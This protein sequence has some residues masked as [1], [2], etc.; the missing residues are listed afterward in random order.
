MTK[1]QFIVTGN[2]LQPNGTP[3][4]GAK[5]TAFDRDMRSEQRLGKATTSEAGRYKITY[6]AGQFSR[7][8]KKSAD[9][10]VRAEFEH[11]GKK[12]HAESEIHFN[13]G[14]MAQIDLILTPVPEQPR[15]ALSEIELLRDEIESLR[16]QV[17][18]P[19]FTADD[20]HFLS[21]ELARRSGGAFAARLQRHAIL[22]LLGFLRQAARSERE[23]GIPLAAFYGWYRLGLP[24]ELDSLLDT[25]LS[26]LRDALEE[27]ISENIIPD[28]LE[29]VGEVLSRITTLHLK[30]GKISIQRFIGQLIDRKSGRP[31]INHTVHLFDP[32]DRSDPIGLGQDITDARGL[33]FFSV[34]L[35]GAK[36][37]DDNSR[38]RELRLNIKDPDGDE[39]AQVLE[40]VAGDQKKP[41]TIPISVPPKEDISA[42]VEDVASS[43]LARVLHERGLHNMTDILRNGGLGDL[44]DIE[45]AEAERLEAHAR[46]SVLSSD[47]ELNTALID[48]GYTGPLTIA[49]ASRAAF[50]TELAP[51]I[52]DYQAIKL[53]MRAEAQVKTLNNILVGLRRELVFGNLDAGTVANFGLNTELIGP[54][55][56]SCK[57]CEASVSPLAYLA[58]LLE[59]AVTYVKDDGND[60]NHVTWLVNAFK[61]P[62]GDL[63]ATCETVEERVRQVRLCVEV[64]RRLHIENQTAGLLAT[65]EPYRHKAYEA[66]LTQLGTSLHELQLVLGVGDE[67]EIKRLGERLAILPEHLPELL[68]DLEALPSPLTEGSLEEIFGLVDTTRDPLEEADTPLLVTW[69]KEYL[70][71]L[72]RNLDFPEDAYTGHA[73]PFI[74]PD[75]IG[76]DDFRHPQE[77]EPAF[78]LWVNRRTL[79]DTRVSAIRE[80]LTV[81]GF[82]SAL[83]AVFGDPPPDLRQLTE[84]LS[85]GTDVQ[86]TVAVLED[87]NLTPER[88]VKLA[89]LQA[90]FSAEQPFEDEE[91][92]DVANILIQVEKQELYESWISEEQVDGVLLDPRMFWQSLREPQ[93][94]EWPPPPQDQPLIDPQVL[95]LK[96]LLEPNAGQAAIDIFNEREAQLEQDYQTLRNT[97]EGDGFEAMMQLALGHPDPGDQLQHD[98]DQL[99]TDLL[100]DNEAS[101]ASAE[102]AIQTDF[103]L[104][105]E[106]FN[107]LM[108]AR[109]RDATPGA[110]PSSEELNQVYAILTVARKKKHRYPDWLLEETQ[111]AV[112]TYWKI[113]KA[114]L[115]RWRARA[116]ARQAWQQAIRSRSKAPLIDPDVLGPLDLNRTSITDPPFSIWR[117]RKLW[118]QDQ[119]AGLR[120]LREAAL[121]PIE[122]LDSMLT[123]QA[124]LDMPVLGV[125]AVDL[126]ALKEQRDAG[127]SISARLEQLN[128]S[129]SAF[130][131]LLAVIEQFDTTLALSN[132]QWGNVESILVEVAKRR[133]AASWR[134]QEQDADLHLG[135][136]FFHLEKAPT[137]PSWR[138]SLQARRT[139]SDRLR[140]RHE[141]DAAVITSL[142]E[143][144]STT[145]EQTLPL[146]RSLLLARADF[147]ENV[148]HGLRAQEVTNRFLIDA[149]ADGCQI[150]TRVS[151]AI[152][153]VQ[154][155]L[156]G[157]R[158]GQ[159][160]NSHP[161][162]TLEDDD[163]DEKWVW[164]GSYTTWRAAMFVFIYPENVLI[165]SLRRYQTPAFRELVN[166]L[167]MD[168]RLTRE[169]ACIAAKTY[170][171][172][173]H[174]IS[175]LKL[176]ASCQAETTMHRGEK[177]DRHATTDKRRLFF[178]FGRGGVTKH[179]YWS[180]YDS[181]DTSG[182]AQTFWDWV[183]G[184][185]DSE[186]LLGAVPYAGFIF[187][188]AVQMSSGE[189]QLVYTRFDLDSNRWDD[190]PQELGLPDNASDFTALVAQQFSTFRPPQLVLQIGQKFWQR[191]VTIEDEINAEEGDEDTEEDNGWVSWQPSTAAGP[192]F[193]DEP[194]ER[195]Y[196][197]AIIR[198]RIGFCAIFRHESSSLPTRYI[199]HLLWK[200][201]KYAS[202]LDLP[203]TWS[204][205]MFIGGDDF[206][207]F[208]GLIQH[209]SQE[210]RRHL[211][212]F[213]QS[214]GEVRYNVCTIEE[215]VGPSGLLGFLPAT[216]NQSSA[217][218]LGERGHAA[219]HCSDEHS[220][221][222]QTT[223]QAAIL[224]LDITQGFI[225]A[226]RYLYLSTFQVHQSS[227]VTGWEINEENRK[228]IAPFVPFPL[229]ITEQVS[230]VEL[231][232]WKAIIRDTFL[233]NEGYPA[234]LITYLQEAYYFVPVHLA[235]Q[236]QH[237]GQYLAA[238]DWLRTVYDY[239]RPPNQR[240]I[241]YGLVQEASL[242]HA[243]ERSG[244]WLL[245]P[246]DPHII[247]AARRNTYTRFTLLSLIRCLLDYADAEYTRDTA[248][249]VPRARELYHTAL[250]L[251]EDGDLKQSTN[252]CQEIIG[253]ITIEVG[254]PFRPWLAAVIASLEEFRAPD[255]LRRVVAEIN[256]LND[257]VSDDEERVFRI[258]E[259]VTAANE[260]LPPTAT[261]GTLAG[262]RREQLDRAHM[263]LLASPSVV[264]AAE[265]SAAIVN[266]DVLHAAS[267]AS[268]IS[269]DNLESERAELP[270]LRVPASQS[271]SPDG[272]M[273]GI[274]ASPISPLK[275]MKAALKIKEPF[276]PAPSYDF[277]IPPNPILTMLALRA[278]VNL[279][280]L[281]HCRNIAG[282]QRELDPY[283]APTDTFSGLPSAFGGQLSLPGITAF[284][285][286]PYRYLFLIDRAKQLVQLASQTETAMLAALEKRDAELYSML[287]ARQEIELARAG[288]RL[289]TLRI[290]EA[291]GGVALA[292][293][294]KDR[295]QLQ[296]D[297]Y[298][299]LIEEGQSELETAALAL[300]GT[301][302]ALQFSSA[303]LSFIAAGFH[304][305]AATQYYTQL[306]TL[307]QGNQAVA[308]ALSSTGSG[309]SSLAGASSTLASLLLTQ[310]S[311]ER[312]EKEWKHSESL[313]R[314]DVAIGEQQIQIAED[315]V[316][317]VEHERK[318]A[319]M[320]TQQ[321]QDTINFLDNKFTNADLYDWM[322]GVLE[323]IYSYFLRHATSTAKLAENQ[324]SFERQQVPPAFIQ[325][326]YWEVP[327]SQGLG[328][329]SAGEGPDRRGLTGSAR[330]LRDITQLDQYALETDR[331]KLQLST[332]LSL[333]RF[334]PI[335]FQQLREGG[336][337]TFSTPM[338]LFDRQ[339]PG[340]YLRLV[341]RVRVSVIA[342]TPTI[343][344][345]H[346][347]LTA[348]GNS[349]V[350]VNSGGIFLSAP[351]RFAFAPLASYFKLVTP[352]NTGSDETLMGGRPCQT[353][354][355]RACAH[356][357]TTT[358]CGRCCRGPPRKPASVSSGCW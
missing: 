178:F 85:Q 227:S 20:L 281:R 273:I 188:F 189:K 179:A 114:R 22:Q 292:Q 297:H 156:W 341:K 270:W 256:A 167:R 78:D 248:E 51:R 123:D 138:A 195:K 121:T 40:T 84:T 142:Q 323:G 12:L 25:P 224:R 95:D 246:L 298:Q 253:T 185:N 208:R 303:V 358:R 58:D 46:L 137:L 316:E 226:R 94:G 221:L 67:D 263:A 193:S 326:D 82:D 16:E 66:L 313:A 300:L 357:I 223:H 209:R 307:P 283:A 158:T 52:G 32:V 127:E 339:F 110:S 275:L 331:R 14:P 43:D 350:V 80:I 54:S 11:K 107:L 276:V 38:N 322:S 282:L 268:G 280:K 10:I 261:M 68:V 240:K 152:E 106:D 155:L 36:G 116:E 145:E 135:P 212:I 92:S 321:A 356:S 272:P 244:D 324:L 24:E 213:F 354:T 230:D 73:L 64:L 251:L 286:T 306:A 26:R 132:I 329:L 198:L 104:S 113:S 174:D 311:I 21:H 309:L 207:D 65:T 79:I 279:F 287:K 215:D 117:E 334:A 18:Y 314:Q 315:R 103:R 177:C 164:L 161:D 347:S 166:S 351:L 77:G 186:K 245:D 211:F 338:E 81:E 173:F 190:T 75:M 34:K 102:E 203:I 55:Q 149:E 47:T 45:S 126:V 290:R 296:V 333:A 128:L 50:V 146:L 170:S 199:C 74:D 289:H 157:L 238:L 136:D 249:S 312:R 31:L 242:E 271:E 335:E 194:D 247:A 98:L 29:R 355:R 141:Q 5:V 200:N 148:A 169:K 231:S 160:R 99:R 332:T 269:R 39:I 206:S 154:G 144:V 349:R 348:A 133:L 293:L 159:L 330:L 120:T 284:T 220:D 162:I 6:T 28:I 124:T 105:I 294:Q 304:S 267:L 210:D 100:S 302:A 108:A 219:H 72:W 191:K 319:K 96:D 15:R 122:G 83:V 131:Y 57:D 88:L 277:C 27:A 71:S 214:S 129:T 109:E 41:V 59:Y 182:Y 217:Q 4:V 175:D 196:L 317:I 3:V 165:P 151:Q 262:R 2:V 93:E 168:Q 89:E 278:E 265:H 163:F 252:A 42:S 49:E 7:A 225:F 48:R 325:A 171:D 346:A 255:Q 119:L 274:L 19:E 76:P 17:E 345:I 291:N 63:P 125:A 258:G 264:R 181:E 204:E 97:Y 35:P 295:A 318:I 336:V 139:W 254:E 243:F 118:V 342:L 234:V 233:D 150:T 60:I 308:A 344:G 257:S 343:Q 176:D 172:Y 328:G 8:E 340:H 305:T 62:F 37:A 235:L 180:A 115:P 197:L 53:K 216:T 236:L 260:A 111:P 337:M 192:S 239:S 153:T 320:Q 87:L 299:G 201:M 30:T 140:S 33:F 1:K 266:T 232:N 229:P 69:R 183:P 56:C 143:S 112:N 147:L 9:V 353:T 61:Q 91:Q 352:G 23:T 310:D 259:I 250:E 134:Q 101:V 13:V 285:P 241:Y 202:E 86:E 187:L 288:V 90:K 228:P 70:R 218:F 184:L 205:T 44:E 130:L 237:R 222:L 301:S 327:D